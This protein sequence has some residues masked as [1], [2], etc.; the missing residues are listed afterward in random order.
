MD[1]PCSRKSDTEPVRSFRIEKTTIKELQKISHFEHT[2]INA[3]VNSVL[4]E[5]AKYF[6]GVRKMD[7]IVIMGDIFEKII[8]SVETEQIISI[9][10][11][12][13]E[14]V[15][16]MYND[17]E[18]IFK[19]PLSFCE[20]LRNAFCRFANW[21]NYSEYRNGRKIII[22]LHHHRGLKWSIFLKSFIDMGLSILKNKKFNNIKTNYS[23]SMVIISI[24]L[25]YTIDNNN[26][27]YNK[28]MF[29]V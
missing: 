28:H 1:V 25:D 5:Y 26:L 10:N 18:D 12:A 27:R 9:A 8:N 14:K 15:F 2:S 17:T 29:S 21:A 23:D 16:K 7:G 22:N 4:K 24:F 13:G 20:H 6:Y 11:E 19:D 3:L